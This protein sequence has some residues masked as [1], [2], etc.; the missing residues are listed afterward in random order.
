MRNYIR[1]FEDFSRFKTEQELIQFYFR[2]LPLHEQKV[3]GDFDFFLVR[4]AEIFK[5]CPK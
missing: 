2:K 3:V 4:C 5:K 1:I